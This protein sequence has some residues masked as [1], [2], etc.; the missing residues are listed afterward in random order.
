MEEIKVNENMETSKKDYAFQIEKQ[1]YR[2]KDETEVKSSLSIKLVF[3]G[4][5]VIGKP[6]QKQYGSLLRFAEAHPE[7]VV[8]RNSI[9][10]PVIIETKA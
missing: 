5:Y 7:L 10:D 3:L 6:V 8:E 2:K 9:D 1:Y 4:G